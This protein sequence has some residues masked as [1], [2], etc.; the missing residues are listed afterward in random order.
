MS[1]AAQTIPATEAPV[2]PRRSTLRALSGLAPYLRRYKGKLV[3]GT[4]FLVL[5]NVIGALLPLAVGT[6]V[7]S[8][9]GSRSMLERFTGLPAFLYNA[10][11]SFYQP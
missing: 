1:A 7:D 5:G 10:L 4:V 11:Q 8:L 6:I 2:E 9:S 3:A